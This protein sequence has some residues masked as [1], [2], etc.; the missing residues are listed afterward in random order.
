MLQRADP[1]VLRPVPRLLPSEMD[2]WESRA[3]DTSNAQLQAF[4]TTSQWTVH[5]VYAFDS[6][7][8]GR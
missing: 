8:F 4:N 7:F 2:A 5:V 6:F 3:Y 1:L